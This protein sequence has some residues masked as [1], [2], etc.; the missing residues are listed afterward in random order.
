MN[1]IG[2]AVERINDPNVIGVRVAV[3]GPRFFGQDAVIGIRGQQRLNNDALAV[4]V[5][6]SHKVVHLLLRN[7]HSLD[8]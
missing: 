7:T 3:R 5:N 8:I 1:E 2:R 6:F 4:L